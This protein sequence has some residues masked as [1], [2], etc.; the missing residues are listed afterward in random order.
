MLKWLDDCAKVVVI[1]IDDLNVKG[2]LFVRVG[3]KVKLTLKA[4]TVHGAEVAIARCW[5]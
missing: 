1:Y 4:I 2:I 5:R 3:Q